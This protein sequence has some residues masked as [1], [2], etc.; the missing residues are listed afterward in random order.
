MKKGGTHQASIT[1]ILSFFSP[2]DIPI[3]I[4]ILILILR[5]QSIQNRNIF[6]T[7]KK[8]NTGTAIYLFWQ[9]QNLEKLE[10]T[11]LTQHGK[12]Q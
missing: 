1:L 9:K 7:E 6:K 8:K 5:Y 3:L 4:L 2:S 12:N 11:I 10:I